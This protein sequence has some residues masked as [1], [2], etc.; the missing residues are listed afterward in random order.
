MPQAGL[1]HEQLEKRV[2]D[3]EAEIAEYSC[4]IDDLRDSRTHLRTLLDFAPYPIV[5]FTLD[6]RVN[7]L[8]PAFTEVFGWTLDEL[9]GKRIPYV[10]PGLEGEV[11]AGIKQLFEERAI[12][13]HETRRLTKDGRVLDVIMRATVY[14]DAE[15]QP[16]GEM[17]ILRDVTREKRIAR[18]N[19]A[20]L[21]ISMALPEYPE[22]FDLLDYV[23]GVIKD[24]LGTE[25]GVVILLDEERQE[26]FFPGVAYDDRSTQKRVKE[27]RFP[28][29]QVDQ[30]I[31]LKGLRTG[32]PIIVN[33]TSKVRRSYPLRDE[34]LGYETRNF[35]QVSLK[36]HDRAIGILC[37]INKK[38]GS[39]DQTDA[40]LL[41]TIAGTVAL[42]I[43]NARFADE[44]K[45]AYKDLSSLDQ[46]KD[47]VIHHL[48]HELKTPVSVIA[49][50]LT[51]LA[52]RMKRQSDETSLITIERAR[53]NLERITDIQLKTED[54]LREQRFQTYDLLSLVLEECG[55][56]L[57]NLFAQE[58]GEVG[59]VQRVRERIDEIFGLKEMVPEEVTLA[60]YAAERLKEAARQAAHRRVEIRHSLH[61]SPAVRIPREA[62]RKI[63][64]GLLKNAIEN[65]PDEG[66]ADVHVRPRGEGTE[67]VVRDFG[68]GI[69]E[70]NQGRIF[71]GFFTT[72]ETSSYSSK[73]PYDFNAGGKGMDLLRI[74]VFSERYGFQIRMDSTRCRFIPDE[75]DVCPG[76]ISVCPACTT[77]EDCRGS[78]GTTFTLYFPPA[79]GRK[80]DEP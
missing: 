28:M 52:K 48:S 19:E 8:N 40:E 77:D 37:A 68:T 65:T 13:R 20:M 34:K 63:M 12:V 70:L 58:V 39:F 24:L 25:G 9:E 32:K 4:R 50:A 75:N 22:L 47:K 14:T 21:R 45:R 17:V 54:I 64:D 38:E 35:I 59:V 11:K 36:S 74:K 53:R 7:F 56:E 18:N 31:V 2:Q 42:S 55:D 62:L 41:N 51:I 60:A 15:D 76:R 49:G 1:S 29:D 57:E 43:E 3:L 46:A 72:R 69:T 44:L 79:S 6:G 66:K 67:L 78:G 5:V 30:V 16:A 10:P 71:E 26:V 27:V 23:S 80:A 73:Q 33:D 61:P